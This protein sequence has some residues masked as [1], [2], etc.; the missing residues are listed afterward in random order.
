MS[1]CHSLLNWLKKAGLHVPEDIG[2]LTLTY[3]AVLG[4]V[5]GIDQNTREAGA[6]AV[7]L[8]IEQ[9]FH[10]ERGIPRKPK[11]VMIEGEWVDGPTVRPRAEP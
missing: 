1:V 5:A 8:V 3:Y 11:V 2:Y 9:L 6:A 7:D 4:A 10:N